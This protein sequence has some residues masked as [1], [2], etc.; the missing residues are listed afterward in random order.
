[1]TFEAYYCTIYGIY[2]L[3]M[4]FYKRYGGLRYPPSVWGLELAA[5]FVFCFL[6]YQR[7]DLGFRANRNEHANATLVFTIFTLLGLLIYLYFTLYTTYVLL[8]DIVCG[9]I[10]VVFTLAEFLIAFY[11]TIIYKKNSSI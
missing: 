2:L 3:L 4:Q 5:I 11:A 7:I 9:S 1:M 10:G 8:F 6:Q